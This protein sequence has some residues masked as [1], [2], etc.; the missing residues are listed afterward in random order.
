MKKLLLFALLFALVTSPAYAGLKAVTATSG[1]GG[2]SGISIG[3]TTI[4]GG[5]NS[6]VL[7]NNAGVVGNDSGFTYRAGVVTIG[8]SVTVPTVIGNGTT[9]NLDATSGTV[10]MSIGTTVIQ[11]NEQLAGVAPITLSINTATFTPNFTNGNAFSATL[12]HASCPCTFANPSAGIVPGASGLIYIVQSASAPDT[13]GT[14]GS[15]YKFNQGV[16]PT[17]SSGANDVDELSFFVRDSTHI[18][19]GLVNLNLH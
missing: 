1:G 4:T 19:V 7:F 18:D 10:E 13:I 3:T 8:T 11:A 5:G 16:A 14:W 6:D 17:L 12:V 15:F 2:S 9:L